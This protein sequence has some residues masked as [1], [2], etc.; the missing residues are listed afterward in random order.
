MIQQYYTIIYYYLLI[1]LVICPKTGALKQQSG[2]VFVGFHLFYSWKYT[3]R[4]VWTS[5]A[6]GWQTSWNYI[7]IIHSYFYSKIYTVVVMVNDLYQFRVKY[8]YANNIQMT[9]SSVC[10]CVFSTLSKP[11]YR[12]RI[13]YIQFTVDISSLRYRVRI[14]ISYKV[15]CLNCVKKYMPFE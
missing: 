8:Y 2:V 4:H 12:N 6:N 14:G 9:I 10:V 15:A 13:M 3:A 5:F 7:I 1:L 11:I